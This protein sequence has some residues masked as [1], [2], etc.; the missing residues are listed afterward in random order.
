MQIE[1]GRIYQFN[2][3]AD[4]DANEIP[5]ISGRVKL[6]RELSADEVDVEEV[7]LMFEVEQQDGTNV[8][9]FLDELEHI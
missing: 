1:L 5:L 3:T 7:G 6:L 4:T 2:P 9:A 8:H